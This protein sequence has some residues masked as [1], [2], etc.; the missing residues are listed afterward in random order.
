MA[1]NNLKEKQGLSSEQLLMVQSEVTR[2]GKSKGIMYLLW[3]FLGVT[4]A[5][6]FYLG[7][8]GRGFLMLVTLGG[9][10]VWA[11]IDVFFIGRRLAI[12]TMHMERKL[13]TEAQLMESSSMI[14]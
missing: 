13:V 8:I 12:K 14:R 6:R 11:F 3:L 10:G 7:D 9:L 2:R 4:G 5:H 1:K